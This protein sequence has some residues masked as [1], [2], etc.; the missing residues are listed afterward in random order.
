MGYSAHRQHRKQDSICF[1]STW[2]VSVVVRC[3][4]FLPFDGYII[5]HLQGP[6]KLAMSFISPHLLET[7]KILKMS[8]NRVDLRANWM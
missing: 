8:L 1:S 7:L 6:I 4:I 5:H 3:C 2:A